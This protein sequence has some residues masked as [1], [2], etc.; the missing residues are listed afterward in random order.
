MQASMRVAVDVSLAQWVSINQTLDI[1][2]P[3]ALLALP[4]STQQALVLLHV[5]VAQVVLTPPV[6]AP[7]SVLRALRGRMPRAQVPRVVPHAKPGLIPPPL[8]LLRRLHAR[9]VLR[10]PTLLM[11]V[12]LLVLIVQAARAPHLGL[13]LALAIQPQHL[14]SP[15]HLLKHLLRQ[16]PLRHLLTRQC[17]QLKHLPYLVLGAMQDNMSH[18]QVA[19]V[20]LVQLVNT[21]YHH[22]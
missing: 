4:G 12:L 21:R 17:P 20:S 6:Q 14:S 1:Q 3:H 15:L 2:A 13:V 11:M 19:P 10:V 7:R 5:L 9:T 22:L 18:V 8:A 16:L